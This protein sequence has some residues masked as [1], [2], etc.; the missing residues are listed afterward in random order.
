MRKGVESELLRPGLA[1]ALNEARAALLSDHERLVHSTAT[2]LVLWARHIR[3]IAC[4]LFVG[5]G[6]TWYLTGPRRTPHMSLSA[7]PIQDP[8]EPVVA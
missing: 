1:A 5:C 4:P 2:G 3:Y 8:T 7:R 6:A